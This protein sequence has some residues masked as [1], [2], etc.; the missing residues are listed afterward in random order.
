MIYRHPNVSTSQ[1]TMTGRDTYLLWSRVVRL[2]GHQLIL[3]YGTTT[4]L[5]VA[6]AVSWSLGRIEEGEVHV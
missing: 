6:A 2:L 5:E 4:D 3:S 1:A